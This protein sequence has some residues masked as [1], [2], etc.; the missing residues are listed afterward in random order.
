MEKLY[1]KLPN[2]KYEYVGYSS[3]DVFP[4]LYFCQDVQNGRRKTSVNY[5]LG[6]DF[7]EP[8]HLQ[9]LFSI[10][11]LDSDLAVYLMKLTEKDSKEFNSAKDSCNIKEPVNFYNIS[12]QDLAILALRF[13]YNKSQEEIS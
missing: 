1:R 9:K 13:L 6:G 2:G 4:G 5:W 7:K 3:P 12:P 10:M 8:V 11:S